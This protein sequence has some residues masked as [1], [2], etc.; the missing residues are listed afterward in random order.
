[1]FYSY[2]QVHHTQN[3]IQPHG[4][5]LIMSVHMCNLQQDLLED[6]PETTMTRRL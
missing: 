2:E 5:I 1:M 3:R 4:D 6:T